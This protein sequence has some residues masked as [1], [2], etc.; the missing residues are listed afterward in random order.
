[1]WIAQIVLFRT[2]QR[3]IEYTEQ[4]QVFFRTSTKIMSIVL[5]QHIKIARTD[6]VHMTVHVFDL[7]TSGYAKTGL[8]MISIL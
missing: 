7:P 5:I 3:G 2:G 6:L 8:Q 4:D 1:M